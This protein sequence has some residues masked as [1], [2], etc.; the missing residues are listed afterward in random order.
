MHTSD[1]LVDVLALASDLRDLSAKQESAVS[2]PYFP[3]REKLV[4]IRFS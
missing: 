2:A 1:K 4:Q 3:K